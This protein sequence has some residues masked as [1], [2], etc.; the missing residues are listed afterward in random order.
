MALRL[1]RCILNDL[2]YV[3]W[4]LRPNLLQQMKTQV[5]SRAET[6]MPSKIARAMITA[7]ELLSVVM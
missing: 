4:L 7:V 6:D 3:S 1:N 2:P 5:I